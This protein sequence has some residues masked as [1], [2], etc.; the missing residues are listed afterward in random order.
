MRVA[1]KL[2]TRWFYLGTNILV[3]EKQPTKADTMALA[4]PQLHFYT[5]NIS[6]WCS[7]SP[8]GKYFNLVRPEYRSNRNM[9]IV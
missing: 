9:L 8:G 6:A 3:Y 7:N 2:T 5:S 1:L 4:T